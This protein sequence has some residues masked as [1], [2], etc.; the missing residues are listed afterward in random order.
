MLALPSFL[1]L[2]TPADRERLAARVERRV[3]GQALENVTTFRGLRRDGSEIDVEAH[4]APADFGGRPAAAG[5]LLDVTERERAYRQVLATQA[6]LQAILQAMS[7]VIFVIDAE[8]RHVKVAPTAQ[9]KMM[10]PPAELLGRTLR[11]I[12]PAPLADRF[13]ALIH[14]ALAERRA[15]ETEYTLQIGGRALWFAASI[16]PLADDRVLWVARDVTQRKHAEE[17][18]R[19]SEARL[20]AIVD[21]SAQIVWATDSEGRVSQPSAMWGDFTGQSGEAMVGHG[22]VE[23]VHPDDRQRLLEAWMHAVT[24]AEPFELVYRVRRRDGAWRQ[25]AVRAVPLLDEHGAVHEWIGTSNDVTERFEADAAVRRSEARYRSLVAASA[26]IVWTSGPNGEAGVSD[27]EAWSAFTGQSR[28]EGLRGWPEAIHPADRPRALAAWEQ[29]LATRQPYEVEY[30]LRRYDGEWRDVLVRGVPMKDAD[31]TITEWIGTITD[32][33]EERRAEAAVRES[34][35][36][37][38]AL[39]GALNEVILV[40]DREGR[41]LKVAPTATNKLYRPADDLLGRTLHEVLP[42]AQADE[43]LRRI[44]QA[45][46]EGGLEE[47]EYSLEIDGREFWF[48]AIISPL[49]ADRVVWMARDVTAQRRAEAALRESEEQLR[50]AQKMEAVGQL[51]GGIAHDFNNLLSAI[52]I[53]C[54]LLR[55]ELP[56]GAPG[57][58]EVDEIQRAAERA[59]ALTR[60]LLAVGRKQKLE[61]QVVDLNGLVEE[62]ELLLD[63]LPGE[64]ITVELALAAEVAPVWADPSQLTQVLLNL[65]VNARDA[66]PRGGTLT[67]STG[68]SGAWVLLG[69]RDTGVGMD[70]ETQ[71]R[72]F[73][74]FFTTKEPGRG[75]GLGLSTVYGIVQQSGGRISVDSA[76]GAGTSVTIAQPRYEGSEAPAH[77]P[78]EP[79]AAPGGSETILVVEDELAVRNSVRRLLVRQGYT[80]LEARHGADAL[81]LL[82]GHSGAGADGSAAGPRIDL[83]LTDLVMPEMGGRDLIDRLRD[84]WPALPLLVMSGYDADAVSKGGELPAGVG[85]LAKPFTVDELVRRVRETLDA[86]RTRPGPAQPPRGP[87]AA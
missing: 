11:E 28:E 73:E 81:R 71:A 61:P 56:E 50:Q 15:E 43:F 68:E 74:P 46:A 62:A 14:R 59:A 13:L 16:S 4:G 20:R 42:T 5:V 52:G 2:I 51:A 80:V 18:L 37:W 38:R 7:E 48:R 3:T 24:A 63:R 22:W 87:E 55:S 27:Y 54:A 65:A 72:I 9:H 32:I 26:Q 66:M 23:A 36:E 69:V 77:R 40:L 60:H 53:N 44:R 8:G 79:V 45:L 83:V 41:Y 31:G 86:A 49:D 19:A 33:S 78:D 30:R 64:R 39:L 34:E 47:V 58:E 82:R 1:S 70:T 10:A 84:E 12:F 29:A 67:V 25:M 21:A 6:E 57:R 75:T 17:A 85:F 35:A 76:P